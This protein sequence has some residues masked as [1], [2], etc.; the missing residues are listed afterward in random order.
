MSSTEEKRYRIM[1]VSGIYPTKEIPH[2][3]TFIKS[4][5]ESLAAAG[6]EVHLIHPKPGRPV[7]VRYATA[8]LQVFF[9]TLTRRFDIVH[10]HS[11]L[12][13]LAARL[14][15]TTPVVA[16][17]LGDDLPGEPLSSGRW[18]KKA[19]LVV[20]MS[21]WLCNAVDAVIVKSTEMKKASGKDDAFVI[22][23]GVDFELF[24]PIPREEA[25]ASLGWDQDRYY[26]LFASNPNWPRKRLH[27]AHAAVDILSERGFPVELVIAHGL[28]Q[29]DVVQYINAS[30]AVVL[31]SIH[32][33]SPNIVKETMACNV[34]V[35]STDVGD[36]S[37]II[38]RTKG[39][40]ICP[41]DPQA[42]A[43]AL[44]EAFQMR[45]PTTGR[46]DI[47]HLECSIVAPQV[48]AVYEQAIRHA[49]SRKKI[50]SLRKKT[51]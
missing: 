36:V 4:Q 19:A 26:V 39:C 32:E 47:K 8:T 40:K 10:A 11:G 38:G 21:H 17:F 50:F 35:V 42:F 5:A 48:I 41:P 31:P 12:W 34:P 29:T 3:G 25:R 30:N 22:P 44:E 51:V 49:N 2:L 14:Q 15:W 20:H 37:Q 27:I 43:A 16:S 1:M 9:K 46:S 13:C 33:G 28:P 7:P 23:N 6:H 24:R 18:S 45:K